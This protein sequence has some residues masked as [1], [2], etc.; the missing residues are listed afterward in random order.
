MNKNT[1]KSGAE[2]SQSFVDG[3]IAGLVPSQVLNVYSGKPGCM[4]GCNGKYWTNPAHLVEAEVSPEDS[5]PRDMTMVKR[6]LG[7]LQADSRR[8]IQDGEILYLGETREQADVERNYVVYLCK[9]AT[10]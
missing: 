2:L 7:I 9:S 3:F 1:N 6:I 5:K 4:C 10:I 8:R